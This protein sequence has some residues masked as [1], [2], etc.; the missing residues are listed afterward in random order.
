MLIEEISEITEIAGLYKFH[1]FG[2]TEVLECHAQPLSKEE[3]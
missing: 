3:I 1:S 2:I